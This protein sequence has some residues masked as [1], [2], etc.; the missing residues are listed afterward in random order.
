MDRKVAGG[1]RSV[2]GGEG[3]QAT[4]STKVIQNTNNRIV[5][6]KEGRQ[7]IH[8]SS[9]NEMK[10]RMSRISSDPYR[11]V[12]G[13]FL[14]S[15]EDKEMYTFVRNY[16]KTIDAIS[17]QLCDIYTLMSV[18]SKPVLVDPSGILKHRPLEASRCEEIREWICGDDKNIKYPSLVLFDEPQTKKVIVRNWDGKIETDIYTEFQ[19]LINALRSYKDK[20]NKFFLE[21]PE[22]FEEFRHSLSVS[23]LKNNLYRVVSDIAIKLF[24]ELQSRFSG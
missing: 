15:D 2:V 4:Y 13:V 22:F 14:F 12:K 17:G 20:P 11:P 21:T 9:K 7:L 10:E 24:L 3:K 5:A 8:V 6:P 23:D 18:V 19:D 16:W 1:N